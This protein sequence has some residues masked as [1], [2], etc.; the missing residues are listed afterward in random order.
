[1]IFLQDGIDNQKSSK[2]YYGR[3]FYCA[4]DYEL[5]RNN[6]ADFGREDDEESAVLAIQINP[7]AKILDMR[8]EKDWEKWQ[9]SKLDKELWR[10]DLDKVAVSYGIDGL[11]DRSFG[12]VVI[13][14]PRMVKAIK[15]N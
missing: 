12:G 15:I 2:G 14:N 4:S 13:Y 5:V 11:F 3:G 9:R 8:N 6:Y 7:K 1:M 10:D